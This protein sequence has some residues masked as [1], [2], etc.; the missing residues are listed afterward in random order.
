MPRLFITVDGTRQEA[1]LDTGNSGG[2]DFIDNKA[3]VMPLGSVP[4]RAG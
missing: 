1:M 3:C 4:P 2:L